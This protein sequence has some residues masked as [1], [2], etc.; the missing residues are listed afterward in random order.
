MRF[1]LDTHTLLW[2]D[3]QSNLLPPEIQALLKNHQNTIFVSVVNAWEMQIKAQS[4][5]LTLH[6]SWRTIIDE[7][8]A[9]NQFRLLP[10]ELIHVKVLDSLLFYHKDPFDRLLIAQAVHENLSLIS[11]DSV[12]SQ[13]PVSVTW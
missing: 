8:I 6:K 11:I 9:I 12:F 3:G 5:K 2:W 4:G 7:Q 1:L 10:V 13:Y